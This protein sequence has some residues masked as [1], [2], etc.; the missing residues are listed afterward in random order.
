MSWIHILYE[1]QQILNIIFCIYE[2]ETFIYYIN[3]CLGECVIYDIIDQTIK[4]VFAPKSTQA[5]Y[6]NLNI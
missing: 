1:P 4:Y 2:F 3:W 6:L 5:L